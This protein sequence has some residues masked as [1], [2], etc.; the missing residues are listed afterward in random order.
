MTYQERASPRRSQAFDN[1]AYLMSAEEFPGQGPNYSYPLYER[2]QGFELC[3]VD[4]RDPQMVYSWVADP[5]FT[6]NP[7]SAIQEG[8]DNSSDCRPLVQRQIQDPLPPW[9]HQAAPGSPSVTSVQQDT[10]AVSTAVLSSSGSTKSAAYSS[11]G[12]TSS[13][14]PSDGSSG[15]GEEPRNT[16]GHRHATAPK[17]QEQQVSWATCVSVV[18]MA[19]MVTSVL[20]LSISVM[21]RMNRMMAAAP[22]G[23]FNQLGPQKVV[24]AHPAPTG[25]ELAQ[26]TKRP[27]ERRMSGLTATNS[28]A[29]STRGDLTVPRA[30]TSTAQTKIWERMTSSQRHRS[31]MHSALSPLTSQAPPGDNEHIEAE[32][33]SEEHMAF[34]FQH[35]M[36]RDGRSLL[37]QARPMCGDVFYTVCQSPQR[38][39]HYRHSTDACVETATDAVHSCNRGTNRFTSLKHCAHSCLGARRPADQCFGMPFF[40]SCA[41]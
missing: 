38:E 35:P 28:R 5:H 41:R 11:S 1:A 16:R 18:L 2:S 13:G 20:L 32:E 7:W 8:V 26:H 29:A 14:R 17:P 37:A 19:V 25:Q 36:T 9:S 12:S 4:E 6:Q 21:V 31:T 22:V 39:F 23:Q 15:S 27:Y 33:G 34:P 24:T 30:P 40:T 10:G 3:P